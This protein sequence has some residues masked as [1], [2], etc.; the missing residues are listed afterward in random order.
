MSRFFERYEA[1]ASRFFDEVITKN[2]IPRPH[3][4]KLL[5]RFGQFSIDDI[6]AR[7]EVVNIFFRNQGITFT[8]YGEEEGV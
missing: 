6:K 1:D 2:G 7:R 8:V 5:H 4:D 3:Y